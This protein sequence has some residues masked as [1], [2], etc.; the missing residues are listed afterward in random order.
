[1]PARVLVLSA[2]V[3][4]G[5]VRAG[6]A[7][8]LALRQ[9]APDAE[10]KHIDVLQL[11]NAPF[12]RVYGAGYLDL[13]NK[14]PHVLG[15]FYDLFDRPKEPTP[16]R[17]RLVLAVQKLN[18]G[19][20]CDLLQAQTWDVIVNTHFLSADIVSALRRDGKIRTPQVTVTTDFDTHRLWVNQPTE[21]YTTATEE[22]A[23]YLAS[24][25][26]PESSIVVTGIPIDPV[27]AVAKDR[28]AL[29]RTHELSND[30][31]IVLQLAGGFGVGPIEKLY[32]GI[33]ATKTPLQ[34]IAVS[35]RNGEAEKQLKRIDAPSR[36]RVKIMGYTTQ[37][38]ELM[39]CAD[40]IV[41]KP[42]GLTASETLA[43][44]AALA[45]VNPIPGQE[46][47]NSDYL[48]ENGAAVK[49]NNVATLPMK[50][51]Y[52]LNNPNH[53]ETIKSNA[54]RLA[55]P[56]AAYDVARLAMSLTPQAAAA[57]AVN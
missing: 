9:V 4:S 52:L 48:L 14:A 33:L 3:G 12:R 26:V 25:G 50:L 5:H 2:A 29:L 28:A 15:Y 10:I 8:E 47:R 39:A 55:R 18:L 56:R 57:A 30:L 32:R 49:V 34:L 27:F 41:S 16:R 46:S 23:A 22:G 11:T 43:R 36:H 17:D 54:R 19:K 24:F 7:I 42:G 51:D 35:G 38:D 31:P 40:I 20:F 1:M 37:I 44:G 53:L 6:Q 21:R 13:V 45:I